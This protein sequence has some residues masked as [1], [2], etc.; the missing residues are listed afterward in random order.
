MPKVVLI[1][2]ASSGIGKASADYLSKKG[3]KVYGTSRK[4]VANNS[5]F[6]MLQ[7]DLTS[8]D[9]IKQ[10]VTKVLEEEK[11]I[12]VLVNNAGI[13]ITGSIEETPTDE[14]RKS[15]ETNYF[16]VLDI[17]KIVL[18]GMRNQKSGLII[19]ITSL[20]GYM[21]L[22]FRGI[23]SSVKGALELVTE[24]LRMEVQEFGIKITNIAPGDYATNIEKGRYHSPVY[25]DS[26][27]KD[28][29]E[30]NLQLM[31]NHVNKGRNPIEI[32]RKIEKIIGA[33]N[34][35]THY[36]VGDGLQKFSIFL[37]RILPDKTFEKL[38]MRYY[39]M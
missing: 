13:G 26:P 5:G 19:N 14:V 7:M 39:K 22:P 20:G 25:K 3:F 8:K 34:P 10:A 38:I 16:G 9:S 28:T 23:Y 31:N 29:Y 33:S 6:T 27:Y 2:G 1:T 24:S 36:R 15:F 4:M 18:P 35:K 32:A 21:G 30:R 37:K 11:K 12:D 17:I